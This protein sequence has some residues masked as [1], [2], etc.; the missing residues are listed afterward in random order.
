MHNLLKLQTRLSSR[1]PCRVGRHQE[2]DTKKKEAASAAA[3]SLLRLASESLLLCSTIVGIMT[4]EVYL[5][6]IPN[7]GILW[8][9]TQ[10]LL[11]SSSHLLLLNRNTEVCKAIVHVLLMEEVEELRMINGLS[12]EIIEV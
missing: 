10:V 3:P 5:S 8:G 4:K 11:L 7:G 12:Q 1:L 2:K 9:V 6:A